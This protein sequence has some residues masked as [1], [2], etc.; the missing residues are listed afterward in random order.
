MPAGS[1]AS[2]IDNIKSTEEAAI[3]KKRNAR[4]VIDPAKLYHQSSLRSM[5]FGYD[6]LKEFRDA[7]M[8][9]TGWG[10]SWSVMGS[11]FIRMLNAKSKPGNTETRGR[12]RKSK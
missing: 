8:I 11:E 10:K 4:L 5:G 12:P 3:R 2:E 6:A 9:V 7:G 1:K